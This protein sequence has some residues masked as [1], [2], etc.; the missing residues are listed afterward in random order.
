M[1]LAQSLP[2][3]P[4][5]LHSVFPNTQTCRTPYFPGGSHPC[6]SQATS[7][8]QQ[9][10]DPPKQPQAQQTKRGCL[11]KD[12]FEAVPGEPQSYGSGFF[13]SQLPPGPLLGLSMRP[14][15]LT[16]VIPE[17]RWVGAQLSRQQG[18][19]HV[20][21]QMFNPQHGVQ[22]QRYLQTSFSLSRAGSA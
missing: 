16:G 11:H 7:L 19:L 13:L 17:M 6:P 12:K 14:E 15:V 2:Y 4:G 9:E 8:L 5:Q 21:A 20:P 22:K 18:P 10:L 1:Q 3:Y